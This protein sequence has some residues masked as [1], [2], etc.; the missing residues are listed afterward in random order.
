MTDI[1]HNGKW[2]HVGWLESDKKQSSAMVVRNGNTEH[3]VEIFAITN[4]IIHKWHFKQ[5]YTFKYQTQSQSL[6]KIYAIT[7]PNISIKTPQR[8]IIKFERYCA[9]RLS[10]QLT[11]NNVS[12]KNIEFKF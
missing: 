7:V 1:K 10:N 11:S 5:Y 4:N 6:D 2:L 9:L 8:Y 12:Y 3:F